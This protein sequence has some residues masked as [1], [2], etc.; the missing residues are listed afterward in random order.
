MRVTLQNLLKTGQPVEHDTDA[1]QVSRMLEAANR[2]IDDAKSTTVSP[3]TRFEA[4]YRAVT[5]CATVALWAN[6]FRLSKI[7]AGHHQT[8]IQVLPIAIGLDARQ[9][10]LLDTFRVKRNAIDYTGDAVDEESLRACIDAA[11]DLLQLLRSWLRA[12]RR[13]LG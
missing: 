9:M 2:N 12:R 1:A 5:Q 3:E 7:Q 6:G 10:R 11:G 4:A 13:D 8:L